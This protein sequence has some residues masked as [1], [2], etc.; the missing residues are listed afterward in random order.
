MTSGAPD[1]FDVIVVGGGPAGLTCSYTLAKKGLR[2]AVMERGRTAGA[3]S[4]FGGRVYSSPLEKVYENFRKEAPIE[5]WVKHEKISMVAD[6]G[7]VSLDYDSNG[8]TSFTAYLPKLVAWMASRAETEGAVIVSD[9]RVD[10]VAMDGNGA[11][12]VLASGDKINADVVVL[13]EG[14]NRLLCE[15]MNVVPPLSLDQVALGVRQVIRLGSDK[16]NERFGLAADEGLA[17]F[18]LG[19]PSDYLPGGG[20]LYTNS[21]TI[22]LGLVLYLEP[23]SQ[24]PDNQVYEIL[25]RFRT[26]P[27][28]GRLLAGGSLVEYGS[29]LIPEAG[30]TMMPDRL[31][32]DGYV[33][34]GDAAGLVLNLGY[35]V[36]GVDFA[37]HSGYLAAQAI[38]DAYS[39]KDFSATK[40]ATYEEKLNHSFVVRE[41]RRHNIIQKM[42]QK[43]YIFEAYPRILVDAARRLYEF[44]EISPKLLEAGRRSIKGRRSTIGVLSDLLTFARGP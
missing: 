29:H 32:G 9:V 10:E 25:E 27:T 22:S 21:S 7:A 42:M 15:G 26:S 23:G 28:L 40:L 37:V 18:F 41:M 19:K 20:F 17:W 1:K 16:I 11:V 34:V 33:I 6:D 2:V 36:R 43:R 44:D 24:M 39:S 4:L 14:V 12:G 38:S 30:L 5:R 31:Y 13:A 3:K 8:S 35:T